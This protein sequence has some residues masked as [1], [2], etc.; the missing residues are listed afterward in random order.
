MK[1]FNGIDTRVLPLIA[2]IGCVSTAPAATVAENFDAVSVSSNSASQNVCVNSPCTTIATGLTAGSYGNSNTGPAPA[3]AATAPDNAN[4]RR[5]DNA[6]NTNTNVVNGFNNAF[7]STAANR[8]LVLGDQAG[9][10]GNTAPA[11]GLSFFRLPFSVGVLDASAT[12]SFQWAFAGQDT[13]ASLT[14]L[15]RADIVNPSGTVLNNILT[16]SSGVGAGYGNGTAN[17][18]WNAGN[19]LLP[20]SY[21]L[22]FSLSEDAVTTNPTNSAVGI[23]NITIAT[24]PVPVPAALPL[25]GS[26]LVALGLI[27]RRNS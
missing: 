6:I 2:A 4:V 14:D 11:G 18:A 12:L 26:A 25:L 7:T 21:F 19:G 13:N 20:G 17:F 22:Q 8:F 1:R 27:R 16:L 23:D 24:V 10:I 15:F 3:G 9:T 5:G